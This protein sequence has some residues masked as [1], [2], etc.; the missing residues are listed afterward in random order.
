MKKLIPFVTSK[1]CK[2]DILAAADYLTSH[3]L[4]QTITL[5]KLL[6]Y[7]VQ[8]DAKQVENTCIGLIQDAYLAGQYDT[9]WN[10]LTYISA[11]TSD[12]KK[13]LEEND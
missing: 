11:I 13:Y 3:Y 5:A 8:Y 10:R 1:E 9:K 2:L 6:E 12:G 7:V 4:G